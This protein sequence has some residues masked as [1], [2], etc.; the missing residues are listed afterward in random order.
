MATRTR[1]RKSNNTTTVREAADAAVAQI[2]EHL[3]EDHRDQPPSAVDAAQADANIAHMLGDEPETDA[4]SELLAQLEA[5][6]AAAR[7][8][9]AEDE[10]E[11]DEE[12]EQDEEI[13]PGPPEEPEVI[14]E[15]IPQTMP[16]PNRFRRLLGLTLRNLK[17]VE[18]AREGWLRRGTV[19]NPDLWF[20]EED[21]RRINAY[22]RG[23][24]AKI[25]FPFEYTVGG[26][27][28]AGVLNPDSR[29]PD[30]KPRGTILWLVGIVDKNTLTVVYDY[31]TG[32][33]SFKTVNAKEFGELVGMGFRL[34]FVGEEFN[35]IDFYDNDDKFFPGTQTVPAPKPRGK[36]QQFLKK[37]DIADRDLAKRLR[38][39]YGI[40][41]DVWKSIVTDLR[42]K[43][44]K[45]ARV[46]L[47][48][49]ATRNA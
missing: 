4:G 40:A 7:N 14:T 45:N 2:D 36:V 20:T 49:L 41:A 21:R 42:S 33:L 23:Y 1:T 30:G 25:R 43:P 19:V 47:R 34:S 12:L 27:M 13:Q 15:V 6:L 22:H 8:G 28:Y 9:H 37:S 39:H 11:S 38:E 35:W 17:Q 24:A 26:M 44:G 32:T 16:T 31:P 10:E 5:S 18:N 29:T 3:A 46:D 48:P